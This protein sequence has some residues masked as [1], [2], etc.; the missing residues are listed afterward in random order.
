MANVFQVLEKTQGSQAAADFLAKTPVTITKKGC[1]RPAG[2]GNI[3]S[4][5]APKLPPY[6][7]PQFPQYTLTPPEPA[8]SYQ[9]SPEMQEM[10]DR[11]RETT[12]RR[13]EEGVTLSPEYKTD[14]YRTVQE[15][16]ST[17]ARDEERR[18]LEDLA[19]RGLGVSGLGQDIL[20]EV[21]RAERTEM[22][23]AIRDIE[24]N[25]ALENMASKER[26]ATQA[27]GVAGLIGEEDYRKYQPQ[28][29]TWQAE[30][31]FLRQKNQIE[32]DKATQIYGAESRRAAEIFEAGVRQNLALIQ[33]Q[34]AIA[35]TQMNNATQLQIAG[36][37]SSL[38]LELNNLRY[39]QTVE[40][41]KLERQWAMEDRNQ[42][43]AFEFI[44][45]FFQLIPIIGPLFGGGAAAAGAAA[46]TSWWQ[47]YALG[48]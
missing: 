10:L 3:P 8:P 27:M 2:Y 32:Y 39:Q 35:T 12:L 33:G 26:A 43:M 15:K 5:S 40:L 16:T 18:R 28:L 41:A 45:S 24:T 36:M 4:I 42:M 31:D 30:L 17:Q 6:V 9:T 19:A 23:R 22:G 34:I 1:C 47:Q 11:L 29:Y 37:Q 46:P 38:A 44:R 14:M 21:G 48:T 13:M 7:L 20:G 25:L